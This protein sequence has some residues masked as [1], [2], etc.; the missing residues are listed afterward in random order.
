MLWQRIGKKNKIPRRFVLM[1]IVPLLCTSNSASA[2]SLLPSL[3][4]DPQ[5]QSH[6]AQ[7]PPCKYTGDFKQERTFE[8]LNKPVVSTG[9]FLFSCNRGLLWEVRKPIADTRVYST[10]QLNFQVKRNASV[11]QLYGIAETRTAKL[12][13]SFLSG[14]TEALSKDFDLKPLN[15]GNTLGT[16]ILTPKNK[17]VQA[18]LTQLIVQQESDSVRITIQAPAAGDIVI[19]IDNIESFEQSERIACREFSQQAQPNCSVL[20]R[21]IDYVKSH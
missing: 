21:P 20:L 19:S 18:R 2:D 3:L 10:A 11:I 7:Q 1:A 5:K 9:R 15:D 4:I 14:D 12:L 6:D 16:I 8:E 17:S 13:L